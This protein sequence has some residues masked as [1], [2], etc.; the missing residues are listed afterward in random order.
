MIT[1]RKSANVQGKVHKIQIILWE[2]IHRE[3]F[4]FLVFLK[5]IK[6]MKKSL[7]NRIAESR[8]DYHF[9]YDVLTSVKPNIK[10]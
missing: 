9:P 7:E 1:N 4:N 5:Y 3:L 6:T 8:S 2:E 10:S